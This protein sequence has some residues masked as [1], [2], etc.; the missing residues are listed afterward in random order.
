ML[1]VYA[2]NRRL[3]RGPRYP[4]QLYAES[5][6][7]T[8]RRVLWGVGQPDANPH[9]SISANVAPGFELRNSRIDNKLPPL[10]TVA[11]PTSVG[12]LDRVGGAEKQAQGLDPKRVTARRKVLAAHCGCSKA[13]RRDSN[14]PDR[15]GLPRLIDSCT[16]HFALEVVLHSA[17]RTVASVDSFAPNPR[18]AMCVSSRAR[19]CPRSRT[20][21]GSGGASGRA[22]FASH[23]RKALSRAK[24]HL[25]YCSS[26]TCS[27]QSTTLPSSCSWMAICVMAVVG[28]A[29]CQCFSPGGNQTTSPGWTSS[30]GPPSRWTRPQPAVMIR[31]CPSGWVCHAVRAPGSNVTLAPAARAGACAWNSGSMRTVPVN[32][33]A[34][35]LLE[36]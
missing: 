5:A 10:A 33:S 29:P 23:R 36:G 12:R 28:A 18:S 17:C 21:F 35:P 13:G 2:G 27:S 15:V 20:V 19:I 24:N 11:E 1:D 25:R 9:Q 8:H 30:T 34:G 6:A 3:S 22:A 26:L 14:E 16:G 4:I 7:P 31:V 32:Q